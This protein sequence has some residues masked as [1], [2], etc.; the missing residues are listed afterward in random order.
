[1]NAATVGRRIAG[2]EELLGSRLFTR[3]QDGFVPTPTAEAMVEAAEQMERCSD[4]VARQVSGEDASLSGPVRLAATEDFVAAF[5]VEHLRGIRERHPGIE[6]RLLTATTLHDLSR[7]EADLALRFS[8]PG[9]GV[10]GG[11]QGPTDVL[12]RR[13]LNFGIGVFGSRAYLR[14]RGA[15]AELDRFEGHD[16]VVVDPEVAAMPGSDWAAAALARGNRPA[17]MV[18]GLRSATSAVAAGFGLGALPCF[19]VAREPWLVRVGAPT[20]VD[21]RELWLMMPADLRRVARVRAVRDYLVEVIQ[22]WEPVLAGRASP[23]T[24]PKPR[25]KRPKPKPG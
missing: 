17:L 24:T 8:A 10:P 21:E 19:M 1:V 4:R 3:T 14:G 5:L 9:R 20:I 7:G 6:L 18:D 23:G 25:V 11:R 22:Q 13:L 16:L 2:F 12:A 15:P